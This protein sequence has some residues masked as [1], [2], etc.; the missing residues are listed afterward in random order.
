MSAHT[1]TALPALAAAEYPAL[2][3]GYLN[4]ATL[5]LAPARTLTALRDALD[6]WAV[7]RP[8]INGYETA[9]ATARASFAR[10][11]GVPT[12]Q[13]ALTGTIAG[14]V[15]LIASALP[16]GAEVVAYEDDF[17]A[18]VHPFAARPDLRLRLVPLQHV[19]DAV[20]PG[21]DLVAV[22]TAQSADGRVADLPAIRAA[23]AVHG[24][25]TLLDAT[26]SIGWLPLDASLD[27]YVVCHG[28]KW[29]CSPHG[30]CFLT[31][32]PGAET[33]LAATST[34]WYAADDPWTSCYGPITRLAPGARR[35]DARPA[36]LS[37]VG[38]AASLSLIEELGVE[39]VH[40][41][42]VALADRLR[43][44]FAALGYAP[45]PGPSAIVAVPDVPPAVLERLTAA[46]V[47]F[48]ARAGNLRFAPHFYNSPADVD[49]AV[50]AAAA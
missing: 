12:A 22:S 25:R 20:G 49:H 14:T 4:T 8:D 1:T 24:A 23:A 26:Q 18:L 7:G 29:L 41:H 31:L 34:G 46:G 6:A 43:D 17:S 40:A 16:Q 50:A 33:T 44:G 21:T 5:G 47:T 32:R 39:A 15:G 3:T 10:I 13:V 42:D 19:A 35:F 2:P 11:A 45:V 37:Y 30:A 38:A 36:Y 27:D 9:A 28:Y 48:S